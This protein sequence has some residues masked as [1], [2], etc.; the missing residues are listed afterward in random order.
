MKRVEDV[1]EIHSSPIMLLDP[2]KVASDRKYRYAL[3]LCPKTLRSKA[4][5]MKAARKERLNL[6]TG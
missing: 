1:P 6:T 3:E 5:L 4:Q 2:A